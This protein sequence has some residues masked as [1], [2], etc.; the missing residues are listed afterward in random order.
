[1]D[2]HVRFRDGITTEEI[3]K[4][5]IQTAVEKIT[6]ENPEWQFVASKLYLYDVFKKV[7]LNRKLDKKPYTGFYDFIKMATSEGWYSPVI[8]DTYPKM[9]LRLWVLY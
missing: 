4:M 1:M 9:K 5:V 8:L 2:A 7:C 6:H 3:Q